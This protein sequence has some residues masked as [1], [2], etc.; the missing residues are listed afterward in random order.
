M[1]RRF[2]D[3]A[4]NLNEGKPVEKIVYRKQQSEW[5]I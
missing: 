5:R 4:T 2:Y 3:T 1:K